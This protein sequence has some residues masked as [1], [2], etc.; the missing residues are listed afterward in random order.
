[1]GDAKAPTMP[2]ASAPRSGQSELGLAPVI[3]PL[4]ALTSYWGVGGRQH[5]SHYYGAAVQ[6]SCSRYDRH[7]R[8]DGISTVAKSVF[9]PLSSHRRLAIKQAGLTACLACLIGNQASQQAEGPDLG[10]PASQKR[11]CLLACL[12][13]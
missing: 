13:A 5:H 12:P 11:A 1:M 8:V 3:I 9:K 4:P 7:L 2:G 10:K 6:E